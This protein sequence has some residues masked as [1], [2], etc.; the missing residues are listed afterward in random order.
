MTKKKFIAGVD[1]STT[2]LGL[3]IYDP[4]IDRT[5]LA[6]YTDLSKFDGDDKIASAV[7]FILERCRGKVEK[8]NI[9]DYL[10]GFAGGR[11]NMKT[12][13]TLAVFN[14]IVGY[15]LSKVIP[16]ERINVTRA[17]KKVGFSNN[18]DFRIMKK[19]SGD[20]NYTKTCIMDLAKLT[21]PNFAGMLTDFK[22]KNDNYRKQAY[23]VVD[24]WVM[25]RQ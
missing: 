18:R 6:E 25:S 19:I 15:E 16:I 3:C 12:I 1:C 8:I 13:L 2:T 5:V 7:Y 4:N 11:T 20:K 22:D 23:D 9:E 10:M 17:R 21:E 24:A 14:G